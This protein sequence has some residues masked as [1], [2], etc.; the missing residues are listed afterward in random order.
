MPRPDFPDHAVELRFKF[1]AEGT[2]ECE[3]CGWHVG[4]CEATLTLG[5]RGTAWRAAHEDPDGG[6]DFTNC[7]IL[8][9]ACHGEAATRA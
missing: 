1:F 6:Y 4:R 7:R 3:E 5:E 2:C 9:V 8:C